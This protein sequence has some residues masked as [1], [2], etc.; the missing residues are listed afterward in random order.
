MGDTNEPHKRGRDSSV[1][2][3]PT[4]EQPRRPWK[5]IAISMYRS[6]LDEA[7]RKVAELK[8]RGIYRASRSWLIRLALSRL[9]VD[10]V[11]QEDRP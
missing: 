6:D 3:N 5:V 8:K 4:P 10:T 7:D 2:S 9:D 1:R 11:T